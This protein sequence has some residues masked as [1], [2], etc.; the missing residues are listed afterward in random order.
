MQI[1]QTSD[2]QSELR[3][4]LADTFLFGRIEQ[5]QDDTPLMDN[6]VDSHGVV[7]LVTFL[8]EH[9]AIRVE[10]EEV[11]TDNL[12]SINKAVAYVARKLG[13]KV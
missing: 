1:M 4:F 8:Q 11:N 10:D 5:L 6:V 7:E 12:D 13:D 3:R 9:F 2:I